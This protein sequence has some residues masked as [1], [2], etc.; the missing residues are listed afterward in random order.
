MAADAA[1]TA[2]ELVAATAGALWEGR[3]RVGGALIFPS[4]PGATAA[5][6]VDLST[7]LQALL[8]FEAEARMDRHEAGPAVS[9]RGFSAGMA[10]E[11]ITSHGR[12]EKGVIS[13]T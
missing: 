11:I 7:Q 9:F 4:A 2:R 13:D 5:P 1:G 8:V 6:P 12:D 3:R 10:P